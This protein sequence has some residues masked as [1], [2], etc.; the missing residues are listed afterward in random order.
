MDT[1]NQSINKLRRLAKPLKRLKESQIFD[2]LG[3]DVDLATYEAVYIALTRAKI[4]IVMDDDTDDN[5]I[6]ATPETEWDGGV[7]DSVSMFLHEVGQYDLLTPEEE[8]D[9]LVKVVMAREVKQQFE[10]QGHDID[11]AARRE[12]EKII[13][14]GK[15]AKDRL[16]EAN[17]RLVISIA[18]RYRN[19][20]VPFLDLIQDGS[21]GLMKAID[22][23]DFNKGAKLSTHATWWIRQAIL[24]SL[25]NN[26]RLV[27]VPEH[28]NANIS[29]V[30]KACNAL[31]LETGTEPTDQEISDAT[32]IPVDKISNL[33]LLGSRTVSLDASANEYGDTS[34]CDLIED[35]DAADPET[36]AENRD[37]REN[38]LMIM[39]RVLRKRE[40][41]VIYYRFGLDDGRS[42]TLQE[43]ANKLHVTRERVR[44]IEGKALRKLYNT[45]LRKYYADYLDAY[46]DDYTA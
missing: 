15:W 34:I 20:G 25:A 5:D 7:R 2:E 43:V 18:K 19:R 12:M 28:L 13:K 17:L 3:D 24:R 33:R 14:A 16:T 39:G 22:K 11:E 10:E 23:F 30:M 45:R 21:L 26:S 36:V 37:L 31:R 40:Q 41:V 35:K 27:R 29:K 38:L 44:Q 6:K 4:E 8:K 1:I 32:Q 42:K 9:L 46:V